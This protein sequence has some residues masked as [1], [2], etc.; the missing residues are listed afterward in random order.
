MIEIPVM[1]E[2]TKSDQDSIPAI[3]INQIKPINST[4]FHEL[5]IPVYTVIKTLLGNQLGKTIQYIPQIKIGGDIEAVHK[6]RVGFR[7]IRSQLRIVKQVIKK[8]SHR[9]LREE[10]QY[11]GRV[12]GTIRDLDVLKLY[13]ASLFQEPPLSKNFELEV[14]HPIFRDTYEL[15]RKNLLEVLDSERFIEFIHFFKSFCDEPIYGVKNKEKRFEPNAQHL[16]NFITTKLFEQFHSI[17]DHQALLS[18]RPEDSTFHN[19][20]IEV[21]RFRYALDFFTPLLNPSPTDDLIK[22]LTM[23]QDKLGTINDHVTANKIMTEVIGNNSQQLNPE[24]IGLLQK[25]IEKSNRE[26]VELQATFSLFWD[27]FQA[28]NPSARMFECV[29]ESES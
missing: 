22:S 16:K 17:L 7:R 12:L 26:K 29:S 11:I 10:S 18:S 4:D 5:N 19:L 20:R 1:P 15:S 13:L 9:Y 14:W 28:E 23:L 21:K 2:E 27:S 6:T 3:P 24:M 25:Y 8:K